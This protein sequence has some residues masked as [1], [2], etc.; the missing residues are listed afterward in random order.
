[1]GLPLWTS[2]WW[3]NRWQ[4]G[5]RLWESPSTKQE[6]QWNHQISPF[7]QNHHTMYVKIK[8][9][10]CGQFS[11][12]ALSL[13]THCWTILRTTWPR[14]E[15]ET[16]LSPADG[17]NWNNNPNGTHNKIFYGPQTLWSYRRNQE[18]SAHNWQNGNPRLSLSSPQFTTTLDDGA[19]VLCHMAPDLCLEQAVGW[20]HASYCL[21]T[22]ALKTSVHFSCTMECQESFRLT[23]H[24]TL[25]GQPM[26]NADKWPN[27]AD[28]G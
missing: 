19:S 8:P 3:F 6:P 23:S 14:K 13:M 9:L 24:H 7:H 16:Y 18:I 22:T 2:W 4:W 11:L 5:H 27:Q 26:H 17:N 1:M 21:P 20:V 15:K 12:T 10:W 25:Y 28:H